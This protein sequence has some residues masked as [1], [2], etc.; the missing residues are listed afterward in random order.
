[1]AGESSKPPVRARR[2][3]LGAVN[4]GEREHVQR[5]GTL[6]ELVAERIAREA[7]RIA[8]VRIR[9]I[10]SLARIIHERL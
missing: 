1:M 6:E 2:A 10:V 9:E 5:L 8:E 4:V 3:A 7:A